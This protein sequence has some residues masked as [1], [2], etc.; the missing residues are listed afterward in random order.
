MA[1]PL[2]SGFPAPLAPLV[3]CGFD[4]GSSLRPS[5]EPSGQRFPGP[6]FWFQP[7]NPVPA[8]QRG[9]SFVLANARPTR[10][11]QQGPKGVAG[12]GR[13]PTCHRAAGRM[14]AG[15]ETAPGA[16]SV[17]PLSR[18]LL[19]TPQ[20]SLTSRPKGQPHCPAQTLVVRAGLSSASSC[21]GRPGW[22][23]T[24]PTSCSGAWG[25]REPFAW[26][27]WLGQESGLC[28]PLW[29]GVSAKG[30]PP[31]KAGYLGVSGT[32]SVSSDWVSAGQRRRVLPSL[33][34]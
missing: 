17:Q 28:S 23:V 31:W 8:S 16:G 14:L 2:R 9:L 6:S 32:E 20:L 26:E 21:L 15:K 18:L 24:S 1:G 19:L 10:S 29:L 5:R 33:R 34:L 4:Y 30:W 13:C 22:E 25:P 12:A 27:A 3:T 7:W 11:F